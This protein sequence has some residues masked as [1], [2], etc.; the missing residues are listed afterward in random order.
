MELSEM[1]EAAALKVGSKKELARR[2][3]VLPQAIANAKAGDR[4]LPAAACG[5]LGDILGID[6]FSVVCASEIIGEKDPAKKDYLRPFA[7]SAAARLAVALG[8]ILITSF[9][10]TTEAEAAPVQGLRGDRIDI[11]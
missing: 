10:N 9:V 7:T 11:M 4:G 5:K 2:L 1:I 3:G 6:R 8:M